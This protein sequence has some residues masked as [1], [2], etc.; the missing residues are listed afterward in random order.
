VDTNQEILNVGE[1]YTTQDLDQDWE[2]KFIR[3]QLGLFANREFRERILAQEGRAGWVLIEKVD[4]YQMR[5]K[6]LRK[7]HPESVVEDY[8]PYRIVVDGPERARQS[9]REGWLALLAI[10]FIPLM[11]VIVVALLKN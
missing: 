3:S 5:L 2:F 7:L 9:R 4:D 6:R 1:P 10:A 8:D 11:I